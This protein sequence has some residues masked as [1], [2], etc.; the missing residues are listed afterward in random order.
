MV[1]QEARASFAG[2]GKAANQAVC[3]MCADLSLESLLQIL[4]TGMD[5][6]HQTVEPHQLL[7]QHC[8]SHAKGWL[9]FAGKVSCKKLQ[10]LLLGC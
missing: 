1:G 5:D 4:E 8:V 10:N 9:S 6:L 7:T 2:Q 3:S